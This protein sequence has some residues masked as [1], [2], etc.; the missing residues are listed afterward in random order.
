MRITSLRNIAAAVR[1]RRQVLG[2]T[3]AEVADLAGVSR[4]WIN[5]FERGK[6][7]VEFGLVVRLIAALGL[8]LDLAEGGHSSEGSGTSVDLDALLDTYRDQ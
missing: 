8:E 5:S 1:G 6:T 4:E 3:Q 2:L 7:T